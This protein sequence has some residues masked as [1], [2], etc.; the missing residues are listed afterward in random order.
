M[1]Y[2][3][4]TPCFVQYDYQLLKTKTKTMNAHVC[5]VQKVKTKINRVVKTKLFGDYTTCVCHISRFWSGLARHSEKG[6]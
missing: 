2:S 1:K 4:N 6:V 3:L 5:S